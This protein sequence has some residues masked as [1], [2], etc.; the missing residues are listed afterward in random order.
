M[1]FILLNAWTKFWIL[2]DIERV[3]IQNVFFINIVEALDM[4]HF[5]TLSTHW[6]E[7]MIAYIYK[8]LIVFHNTLNKSTFDSN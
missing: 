7:S 6:D 4:R 3:Y 2:L 1:R 5:E 8:I